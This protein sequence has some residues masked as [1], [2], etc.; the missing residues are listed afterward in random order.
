MGLKILSAK[1]FS[2]KLKATIHST[3]KLG[4]TEITARELNLS[5]ESGIKFAIDENDS[6]ALYLISCPKSDEESFRVL[7]AGEYYSVNTKALFD[8]L[9]YDYKFKNIMFDIVKEE[10]DNMEVYK[11]LKR[12]KPRKQKE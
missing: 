9:G 4:F 11:L 5:K 3:G 8:N 12:E 1:Q 7:K 2:V 6:N 10:I